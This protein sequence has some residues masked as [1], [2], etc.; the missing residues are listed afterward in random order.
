MSVAQLPLHEPEAI[1]RP[2]QIIQTSSAD[3]KERL[4][5]LLDQCNQQSMEIH[6]GKIKTLDR[7]RK[8]VQA[9][10]RKRYETIIHGKRPVQSLSEIPS[11]AHNQSTITTPPI[12]IAFV[13]P[14]FSHPLWLVYSIVSKSTSSSGLKSSSRTIMLMIS[15]TTITR[16]LSG[17]TSFQNG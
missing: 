14:Q 13:Y 7:T 5:V 6:C 3:T 11:I 16:G 2:N 10:I 8:L 1:C 15:F 9:I 17:N 4:R 12:Y